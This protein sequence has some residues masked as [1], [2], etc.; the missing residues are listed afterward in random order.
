M[1]FGYSEVG[2][3]DFRGHEL[4][5]FAPPLVHLLS[6]VAIVVFGA[7][8]AIPYVIGLIIGDYAR[9]AACELDKPAFCVAAQNVFLELVIIQLVLMGTRNP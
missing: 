3:D 8:G 2:C 7:V 5:Y 4:E 9:Q 1:L 6:H